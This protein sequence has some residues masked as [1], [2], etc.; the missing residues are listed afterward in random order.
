MR[1]IS[2]V[3]GFGLGNRLKLTMRRGMGLEVTPMVLA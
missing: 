1:S 2:E 3:E